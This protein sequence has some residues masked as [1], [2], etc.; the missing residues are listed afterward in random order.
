MLLGGRCQTNSAPSQ[1]S[2]TYHHTQQLTETDYFAKLAKFSYTTYQDD[3]DRPQSRGQDVRDK[4]RK[5][6]FFPF[7]CFAKQSER[8]R[9]QFYLL[10]TLILSP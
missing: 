5:M 9:E 7:V 4:E 2:L 8:E 6:Q 10:I 3:S 1:P